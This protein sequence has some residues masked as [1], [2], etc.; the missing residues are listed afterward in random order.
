[1]RLFLLSQ[2]PPKKSGR[3]YNTEFSPPKVPNRDDVTGEPLIRR[4]DD[5]PE[6]VKNRLNIYAQTTAP[7]LEYFSQR[8]GDKLHLLTCETSKEGYAKVKPILTKISAKK[9]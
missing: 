5:E 9:Q 3:V 2:P 8:F 1:L 7:I 6:A 4:P